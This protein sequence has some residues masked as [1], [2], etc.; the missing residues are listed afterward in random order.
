MIIRFSNM[1]ITLNLNSFSEILGENLSAM[2]LRKNEIFTGT[3]PTHL[4]ETSKISTKHM[5][6]WFSRH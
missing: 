3:G 5:K 1:E 6:Q 2:S 4:P